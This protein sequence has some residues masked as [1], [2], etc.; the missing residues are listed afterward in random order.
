MKLHFHYFRLRIGFCIADKIGLSLSLSLPHSNPTVQTIINAHQFYRRRSVANQ[1]ILGATTYQKGREGEA[2]EGAAIHANQM[3]FK[4]F[5]V[6]THKTMQSRQTNSKQT[7]KHNWPTLAN[8]AG[9][10][11]HTAR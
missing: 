5:T 10:A 3:S 7:N 11:G 1:M 9:H 4:F 8:A 6:Q 2:G